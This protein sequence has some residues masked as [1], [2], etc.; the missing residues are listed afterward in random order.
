MCQ[1][2]EDK[3]LRAELSGLLAPHEIAAVL[4]SSHKPT[5]CLQAG[6]SSV[7]LFYSISCVYHTNGDHGG[8]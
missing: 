1:L 2:R 4:A 6:F 8:M 7:L 5:F 3:D